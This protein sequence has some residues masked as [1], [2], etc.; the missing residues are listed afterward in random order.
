MSSFKP[1]EPQQARLK[2]AIYGPPGSG[3]TFT[4]LLWAE[5]LAKSRGKKIAF[6]DTERGTDFYAQEVKNRKI[7]PEAFAFDAI[8][9]KSLKLV[10]DA[11]AEL[12]PE[13][14][15]VVVLDSISHLWDSAIEAYEG[16]KTSADT[17]PM[18]AWGQ[19]K[20]PYKQLLNYLIASPFDVFILGRQGNVFEEDGGQLR[21]VGVKM[22]AEGETPHEPHVCVRLENKQDQADTTK[23]T[24]LMYVE[25]DRTG[26]L[27]GQTIANPNFKTIEV[28]LPYLGD[29]QAPQ[30][31]DEER[32][33]QDAE[34][35]A[36]QESAKRNKEGKSQTLLSE[37]RVQLSACTDIEELGAVAKELKKKRRYLTEAHRN[38]LLVL[39]E[40]MRDQLVKKA[41]GEV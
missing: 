11:I 24:V 29:K 20:K 18:H 4:S 26:I 41:T 2:I 32:K 15:G 3:K 39:F 16:Q 40:D 19:I 7:H 22:K 1:A 34:L 13:E 9:T 6:V 35:L 10:R 23:S 8:Y 31:D 38:A 33:A 27:Q 30:E 21:K 28:L 37:F 25:K 5:G 14:Y 12:D 36:E 17:I